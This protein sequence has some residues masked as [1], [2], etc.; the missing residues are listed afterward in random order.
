MVTVALT[1]A[2]CSGQISNMDNPGPPPASTPGVPSGP[3][4]P[5]A[6]AVPGGITSPATGQRM[7]DRQ[8]LNVITDLFGV[9][10]AS[11]ASQMPI[12]P[13][14][15]GFR[16]A[17]SVLLPSDLRIEGY[18]NLA[19]FVVGKIDWVKQLGA[20][21]VCADLGGK[22]QQDFLA[23]M[24]RRL[25]RRPLT[26]EQVKRFAPIFDQVKTEGDDFATAA[27]LTARAMLQSP[28]FIYRLERGGTHW[29]NYDLATRLSFLVW[30]SVPD[31]ALLDSAVRADFATAGIDGQIDRMIHDPRAKRALRDYVDDWLDADKLL[32]TGRDN[33]MFPLF[34][35]A[36]AS[37]M[38]EE[39]HRLFERIVW[40]ED[41]DLLGLLTTDKTVV[42][43][44]LAKLYGLPAP[45]GTG[46]SEV[47]LAGNPNRQGLL[48]FGGVLTVTSVG[49]AGSS[50]V[51]RGV[52]V[53]RNLLCLNLPEP[54]SNVP[55][56]PD[57]TVGASERNRLAAHRVDPACGACHS[58]ID[59]LGI[60]FEQYDAIGNLQ[61][62]DAHGNALTG[63]GTVTVAGKELAFKNM[64]EYVAAV[65]QSPDLQTCLV[66]KVVQYTLA[67]PLEAKDDP[68]VKALAAKFSQDG[69]R[70]KSLL[71]AMAGSLKAA[72]GG[73]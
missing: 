35:A 20:D 15:E 28:E 70:Y 55:M 66:K 25:F 4:S 50:I 72:G 22:C 47:S 3:A 41:S 36:L 64:R 51:D 19:D 24:G 7:T 42:T 68:L 18:A 38:R 54:P 12:D 31:D 1:A 58:Q 39:I 11:I 73:K 23:R 14:L 60:G 29:D 21:G 37:D 48:T 49:S 2:A 30:N 46:F 5:G 9:D 63:E 26:D 56:L 44:G 53:G 27:S 59:P 32:R 40:T 57:E 10:A 45:A 71:V 17:G 67:R 13:K 6:P 62:K 61:A 33:M 65:S 52:F 16:N 43:P 34:S 69:R 8:Y